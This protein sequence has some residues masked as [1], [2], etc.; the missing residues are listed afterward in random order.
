MEVRQVEGDNGVQ[1]P[2]SDDRVSLVTVVVP[3]TDPRLTLAALRHATAFSRSLSVR[4]RLIDVRTVPF[5][6]DLGVPLVTRD[7]LE[8]RLRAVASLAPVPVSSEIVFARDRVDGF[9]RAMLRTSVVVIAVR[10]QW[11]PSA[12]KRLA[13]ALESAGFQVVVIETN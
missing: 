13:R 12:E 1:V 4:I 5:P 7:F 6:S 10:R 9:V 2:L 8:D 11:W 3:Y